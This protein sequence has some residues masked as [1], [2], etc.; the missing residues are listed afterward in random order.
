MKNPLTIKTRLLSFW[1]RVKRREPLEIVAYL[2][3]GLALAAVLFGV[4]L[5]VS[6]WIEVSYFSGAATIVGGLTGLAGLLWASA[7]WSLMKLRN[8]WYCFI[9]GLL[10]IPFLFPAGA[11]LGIYTLALLKREETRAAFQR[12]TSH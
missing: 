9:I 8:W 1:Q 11:I 5:V 4:G 10:T 6:A 7:G 3:L 12:K 2:Y